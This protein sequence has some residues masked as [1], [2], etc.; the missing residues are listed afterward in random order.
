LRVAKRLAA[1]QACEDHLTSAALRLCE[2]KKE[3][4]S[5]RHHTSFLLEQQIE[6][7]DLMPAG[8]HLYS[9]EPQAAMDFTD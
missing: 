8:R 5:P 9:T 2:S 6:L 7:I 3:S 4:A 1:A